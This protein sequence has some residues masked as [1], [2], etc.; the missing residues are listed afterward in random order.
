[1]KIT[2]AI[3]IPAIILLRSIPKLVECNLSTVNQVIPPRIFAETTV[4]G[5][6]QPILLTRFLHNKPGVFLWESSKCY[7]AFFEP[8]FI[9]QSVGFLGMISW[10]YLLYH[11]IKNNK[12][13]PLLLLLALP[14]LPFLEILSTF[15]AYAHKVFA[16][17]AI[18][19]FVKNKK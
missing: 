13:Q 8:N 6:N 11:L 4:D 1:M 10:F 2:I 5:Q 7:F 15:S 16:I 18:A 12:W 3:L 17:I 9:Y 14:L 19:V